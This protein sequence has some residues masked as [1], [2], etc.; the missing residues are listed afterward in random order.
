MGTVN[1][2]EIWK[3]FYFNGQFGNV[4]VEILSLS[5]TSLVI[6]N[7]NTVFEMFYYDR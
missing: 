4:T 6:D 7:R 3:C 2:P 1:K 5:L